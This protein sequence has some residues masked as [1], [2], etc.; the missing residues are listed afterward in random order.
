MGRVG[1]TGVWVRRIETE[2][3]EREGW[4]KIAKGVKEDARD[5]RDSCP[6]R[7]ALIRLFKEVGEWESDSLDEA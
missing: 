6:E 3:Q 5:A 2:E 4:K 7:E 1:L